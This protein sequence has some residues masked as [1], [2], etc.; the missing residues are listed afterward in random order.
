MVHMTKERAQELIEIYGR[1]WMQ[2]DAELIISIFT[3]DATYFDPAEGEVKGHEG[4]KNYWETKVLASQTDIDFKLLNVWIDGDTVIAEWNPKYIDTKR[5]LR[6]DMTEV[7][8]FE[9]RDDK[10]SSNRE[11][12]RNVKTPV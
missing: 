8:I 9:V 1:A 11:Y 3:P 4:I 7:A 12:Y 10:F 2:R 6:I 5:Q